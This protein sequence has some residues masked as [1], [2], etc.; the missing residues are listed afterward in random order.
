MDAMRTPTTP[1]A[2]ADRTNRLR[3]WRADNGLSLDE[4]S[5]LTGLS[6]SMLSLAERGLRQLA[7]M[8]RVRV[9]RRLGARVADLFDVEPVDESDDAG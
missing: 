3:L 1:G 6:P 8:T 9:A 7:P 2:V 5:G 4:M